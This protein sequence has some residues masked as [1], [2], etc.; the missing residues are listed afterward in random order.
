MQDSSSRG[1]R[2]RSK[3]VQIIII[4]HECLYRRLDKILRG[5]AKATLNEILDTTSVRTFPKAE[6]ITTGR[7]LVAKEKRG[8][9]MMPNPLYIS[10]RHDWI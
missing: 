6:T 4:E 3:D 1:E 8:F 7:H 9:G 2:E 10:G 5:T